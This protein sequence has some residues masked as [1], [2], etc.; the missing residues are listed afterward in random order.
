MR[1]YKKGAKNFLYRIRRNKD[2]KQNFCAC[3][4]NK[5]VNKRLLNQNY[6]TSIR[7]NI[8]LNFSVWLQAWKAHY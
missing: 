4:R 5:H 7:Q 1:K 6:C 3:K 8:D 2:T